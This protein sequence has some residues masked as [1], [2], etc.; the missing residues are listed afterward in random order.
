MA[1]D[2]KKRIKTGVQYSS[3]VYTMKEMLH[4]LFRRK[5]CPIC[6]TKLI[7]RKKKIYRGYG[8]ATVRSGSTPGKPQLKFMADRYTIVKTFYCEKCDKEY[9]VSEFTESNF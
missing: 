3:E 6:E 5:I 1:E 7:K 9:S 2:N 8:E 4:L